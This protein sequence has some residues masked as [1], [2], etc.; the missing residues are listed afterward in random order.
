MSTK[1]H[2]SLDPD[3]R[4]QG[5]DKIKSYLRGERSYR[6]LVE[7]LYP[8]EDLSFD[9]LRAAVAAEVE[10]ATPATRT[11]V[12]FSLALLR[13][14]EYAFSGYIYQLNLGAH[15]EMRELYEVQRLTLGLEAP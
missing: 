2:H 6:P 11:H 8:G 15:N 10:A 5:I 13:S 4:Q 9:E 1:G 7:E 12:Q 3:T 14:M